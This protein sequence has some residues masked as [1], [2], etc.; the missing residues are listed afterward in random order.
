MNN[1]ILVIED[2]PQISDFIKR[3]LRREGYNVIAAADGE[4]GLELAF[5]ELPDVIILD[6]MLPGIDGL[7]VCR[8][9]QRGGIANT[10]LNAD[11]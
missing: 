5:A 2:E 1:K 11:G 6:I 8:Q 9:N 4:T 7:T 3:G 10:Y